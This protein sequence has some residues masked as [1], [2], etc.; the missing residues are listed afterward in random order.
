MGNFQSKLG[1]LGCEEVHV[2]GEK[3]SEVL[4]PDAPPPAANIIKPLDF[5]P[6]LPSSETAELLEQHRELLVEELKKTQPDWS[7]TSYIKNLDME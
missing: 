4:R 7:D 3:R 5:Q 2:N 1:N 6:N